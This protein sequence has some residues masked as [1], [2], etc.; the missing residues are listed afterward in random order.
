MNSRRKKPRRWLQYSLRS[1]LIA[2][3]LLGVF[4]GLSVEKARRQKIAVNVWQGL[5]AQ[6]V[7]R[8]E[9]V[10][11]PTGFPASTRLPSRRGRLGPGG[12]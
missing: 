11:G 3:A 6:I 7:C 12:C 1:F 2:F 9:M 4:L 8:Q 10:F 5:G